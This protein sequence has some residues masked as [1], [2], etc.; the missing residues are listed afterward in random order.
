M[1]KITSNLAGGTEVW[2]DDINRHKM[3]AKS[4]TK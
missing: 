4:T 3:V 2:V 1:L